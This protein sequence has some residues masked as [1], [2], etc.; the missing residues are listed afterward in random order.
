MISIHVL[1]AF[2]VPSQPLSK[3][4]IVLSITNPTTNNVVLKPS[5]SYPNQGFPIKSKVIAKIKKEVSTPSRVSFEAHVAGTNK[6]L[7]LDGKSR[8]Y[9]TPSGSPLEVVKII[10]S[11]QGMFIFV[12][13]LIRFD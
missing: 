6:V 13:M 7:F 9:V 8:I 11:E 3:F 12:R 10:I 2:T 1:F 4:Y 5:D